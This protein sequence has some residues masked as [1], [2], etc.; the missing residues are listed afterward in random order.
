FFELA[1]IEIGFTLAAPARPRFVAANGANVAPVGDG[2]A[3][4]VLD[5]VKRAGVERLDL[6]TVSREKMALGFE[7]HAG[8]ALIVEHVQSRFVAFERDALAILGFDHRLLIF[9]L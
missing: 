7:S 4:A 2:E 6:K 8:Q 5:D 3:L 1:Q 9:A